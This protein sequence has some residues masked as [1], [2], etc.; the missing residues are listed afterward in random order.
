MQCPISKFQ[1][2]IERQRQS[3]ADCGSPGDKLPE[4]GL[5]GNDNLLRIV[6]C[7]LRIERQRQSIAES[8]ER[9][10]ESGS[11]GD[12]LPDCGLNGNDNP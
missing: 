12:K 10:A 2:S 3:I 11:P 5:N 1:F 4:C 7:G 8:G 9:K 6:E